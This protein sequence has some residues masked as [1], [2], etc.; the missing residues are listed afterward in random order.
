MK[1]HPDRTK[2]V[3]RHLPPSITEGMLADQIDTA[4]AGRYNW[5][6]F[7]PGKTSLKHQ[8]YSR[9]YINF[10]RPEDVIE[11]AEFFEG[12]V[13]VNEK[14]THFKTIVEY[15]PSQRLPKQTSKKDGR[16]GTIMKDPEYLEFLEFIAKPVENLPSAEIQLER[17]EAER[18]GI[19]KEAPIVTP[20]MDYVRQKRASKGGSRRSI[21]NEKMSGR[22]GGSSAGSSSSAPSK[23]NS[24][25][26][27]SSTAMYIQRD[28]SRSSSGKDKSMYILSS[29]R[30]D[31]QL[32]DKA[33][34]SAVTSGAGQP[35]DGNGTIGFGIA[36]A[37]KKKILLLKGKERE[38]SHEQCQLKDVMGSTTDKQKQR[39]E[40]G[41]IIRTILLN[42]DARQNQLGVPSETQTQTMQLGKE[43]RPPRGP[44]T[45]AVPKDTNGAPD[46]KVHGNGL[47]GFGSEK[48]ERRARNKDRPDRGVWA[49]LRR[50][51]GSHASDSTI[52]GTSAHSTLDSSEGFRKSVGRRG[53]SQGGKDNDGSPL[54]SEQK[55]SKRGSASG[56]SSHE[57]QVWV[58]K[59]SSGS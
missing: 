53:S 49:P 3:L 41:R 45:Q 51:D 43:R 10:K 46:E 19:A 18:S 15:A 1:G 52:S 11:F 14:G 39:H 50:L 28:A 17:R 12:H 56:Y 47:S 32:S 22:G 6:S 30:D 5:F 25:K 58:Q 57:K 9:A 34:L 7:R 44:S 40:G 31:P 27:K 4:F 29:K 20:L 33:N 48:L 55:S 59:S 13:F 2:V 35:E 54:T 37:G 26:R 38:I 21:A 36:G 16:E 8:V 23:R 24:E 42:K